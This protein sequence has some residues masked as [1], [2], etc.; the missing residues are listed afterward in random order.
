MSYTQI[1][2]QFILKPASSRFT[3][4]RFLIAAQGTKCGDAT[5]YSRSEWG[6]R[7][8]KDKTLMTNSNPVDLVFIHHTAGASCQDFN[9]CAKVVKGIQAHHMDTNGQYCKTIASLFQLDSIVKLLLQYF[10]KNH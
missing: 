6:A 1:L 5:L 7:A 9:S 2:K 4:T 3:L 10:N 8:P